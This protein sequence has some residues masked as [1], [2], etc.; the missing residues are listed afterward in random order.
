MAIKFERKNHSSSLINRLEI[1][2]NLMKM[3]S[4]KNYFG[5]PKFK[6]FKHMKEFSFLVMQQL[7]L[8]LE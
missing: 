1:E 6:E 5:F 8:N 7:G 3:L 4:E 2:A